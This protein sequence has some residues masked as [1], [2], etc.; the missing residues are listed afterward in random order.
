MAYLSWALATCFLI[1]PAT[2]ALARAWG[3][4]SVKPLEDAEVLHGCAAPFGVQAF[5]GQGA[6]GVHMDPVVV[7]VHAQGSLVDVQGRQGGQVLDGGLFPS[8]ERLEQRSFVHRRH[9]ITQPRPPARQD[10]RYPAASDSAA[11]SARPC[12]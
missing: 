6:G 9:G 11:P 8:G 4:A 7:A 3:F 2:G 1:N 12:A 5:H 10:V